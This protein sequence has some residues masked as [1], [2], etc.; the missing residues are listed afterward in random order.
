MCIRDR[1]C[2]RRSYT[3]KSVIYSG[4]GAD[5]G[6]PIYFI[7]QPEQTIPADVLKV[8]EAEVLLAECGGFENFVGALSVENATKG[9]ELMTG[10][11]RNAANAET[12][13]AYPLIDLKDGGY[14]RVIS[15]VPG[16]NKKKGLV[17]NLSLIHICISSSVVRELIAFGKDVTDF[18]P[19]KK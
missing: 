18:L 17:W 13:L 9:R 10:E 11:G 2:G 16:F 7:L 14:Y 8:I 12:V 5:G 4:T 15:A 6:N 19:K 3:K 1:A